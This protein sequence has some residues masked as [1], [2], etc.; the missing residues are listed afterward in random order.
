M[1]ADVPGAVIV[2]RPVPAPAT[3]YR[4]P[5][6]WSS[7]NRP[8]RRRPSRCWSSGRTCREPRPRPAGQPPR[9]LAGGGAGIAVVVGDG[10]GD[11]VGAVGGVGVAR[12]G[13]GA[14]GVVAE[15]PGVTGDGAV[16]IGGPGATQRRPCDRRWS[17]CRSP[18]SVSG[19]PAAAYAES[20]HREP[21]EGQVGGRRRAARGVEVQASRTGRL[22]RRRRVGC[23]HGPGRRLGPLTGQTLA[24]RGRSA[25]C[26][27]SPDELAAAVPGGGDS[28]SRSRLQGR[29]GAVHDATETQGQRTARRGSA[30][31]R[32]SWSRPWPAPAER[33]TCLTRMGPGP[34]T[35]SAV[36]RTSVPRLPSGCRLGQTPPA[37]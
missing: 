34:G 15:A 28:R 22:Q 12:G 6:Q 32:R 19:S 14:G 4:R 36:T 31:W 35:T 25:T 1:S 18:R 24:R 9:D 33:R 23:R 10:Q 20:G 16:G 29:L 26:P 21:V 2:C 7:M 11:G 27:R 17:E 13:A 3:E 37:P 30:V 8:R 5:P